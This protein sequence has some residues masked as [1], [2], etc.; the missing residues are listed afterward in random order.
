MTA[1]ILRWESGRSLHGGVVDADDQAMGF[2]KA[3]VWLE[4]ELWERKLRE[5]RE[6][7]GKERDRRERERGRRENQSNSVWLLGTKLSF[8]DQI[9]GF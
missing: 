6:K 5:E 2:A 7:R 1:S 9:G 4:R 8:E 3:K